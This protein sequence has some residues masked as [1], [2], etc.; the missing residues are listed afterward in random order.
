MRASAA[1]R[2]TGATGWGSP[3]GEAPRMEMN[4]R[5]LAIVG[6]TATGKSALAIAIAARV[7][8]EVVSCDSTAVYRGFDIGTDKVPLAERAGIPHHMMDVVAPT[9][10]YSAARYERQAAAVIRGI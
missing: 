3:R 9:E 5:L 4:H 8:G 6:P 10:E 7:G 1:T 2:A